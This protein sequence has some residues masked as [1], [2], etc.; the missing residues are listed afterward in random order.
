MHEIAAQAVYFPILEL[1]T[2]NIPLQ[3]EAN[4]HPTSTSKGI[5]IFQTKSSQENY[6]LPPPS[7]QS[8]R[9]WRK[10]IALTNRKPDT[11]SPPAQMTGYIFGCLMALGARE[12][13]AQHF[14]GGSV[15]P[16][17][18]ILRLQYLVA[19]LAPSFW[20]VR[21]IELSGSLGCGV[22]ASR[23]RI[24]RP[25]CAKLV[26]FMHADEKLRTRPVL[27]RR[28]LKVY[29]RDEHVKSKSLPLLGVWDTPVVKLWRHHAQKLSVSGFR[30]TR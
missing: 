9:L 22:F 16:G 19:L 29:G 20:R 30:W 25:S 2:W 11:T 24:L 7:P 13:P 1:A 28:S 15:V 14:V 18:R 3:N 5:R 21:D 6:I 27:S 4:S 26:R 23:C 12:H 17:Q 10:G 8:N